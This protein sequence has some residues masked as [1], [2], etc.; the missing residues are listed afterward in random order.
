M[1]KKAKK[2]NE[3]GISILLVVL[4]LSSL[5]VITLAISNIVL[6]VGRTS[7]QIGYSE[8]AYYAAETGV[9]KALYEIETNRTVVGLDGDSDNLSEISNASWERTLVEIT[10]YL[11]DCATLGSNEGVCVDTA[12]TINSGNPLK[13]NLDADNSFQLDL[14]FSGLTYPDSITITWSGTGKIITLDGNG[15]QNTIEASPVT[16]NSLATNLY[17]VRMVNNDTS[18]I[19]FTITPSVNNL[20]IGIL[21][22]GTGNYQ[23]Q[24]R[25]IEVERKNWQIY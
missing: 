21:L 7:R 4:I 16:L 17:I 23:N 2:I 6:R 3:K 13:I 5:I 1:F 20:P 11:T 8:I 22:T 14:N 18:Q 25:I 9:E 19:A 12:G 15:N 10:S 24:Q